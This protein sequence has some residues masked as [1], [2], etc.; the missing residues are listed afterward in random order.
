MVNKTKD[1]GP[2]LQD[3]P[4]FNYKQPLFPDRFICLFFVWFMHEK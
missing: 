2:K 3:D 4:Y 1:H